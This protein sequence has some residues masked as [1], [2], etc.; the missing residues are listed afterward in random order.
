[1]SRNRQ[2]SH[3]DDDTH[4]TMVVPVHLTGASQ[5]Q[6]TFLSAKLPDPNNVDCGGVAN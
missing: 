4:V 3:L 1:M 5:V 2:K 6:E